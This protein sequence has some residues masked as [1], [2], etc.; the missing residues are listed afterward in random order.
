MLIVTHDEQLAQS[1]DRILHMQD[2]LW[3]NQ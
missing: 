1:A 2:G 3:L